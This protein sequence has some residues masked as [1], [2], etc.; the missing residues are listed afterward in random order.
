MYALIQKGTKQYQVEKDKSYELE[1]IQG[2]PGS[3][4]SFDE[5]LLV[6]D[7]ENCS[8]GKPFVKGAKVTAQIVGEKKGVKTIAFKFRRRKHSRSMKG[9]RQKYTVVKI[10]DIVV[11]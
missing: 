1:L 9:H 11:S 3:E 10:K 7:G 2:E 6:V 8:I 4:I 5:V